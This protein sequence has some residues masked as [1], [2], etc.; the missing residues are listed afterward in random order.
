MAASARAKLE[1]CVVRLGQDTNWWVEE[2]SD[3]I[4]WDTDGLGILD[5]RQISHLMDLA[6]SL[7]DY[8]FDASAFD[9]AFYRFRI[10]KEMPKGRVR[11]VRLRASLSDPD[12]PLFALPDVVDEEKGPY[13]DFLE[14]ITR[15]RV[16]MLNDLVDFKQ[17]LTVEDMEEDIRDR[18]NTD[19]LEGRG[20]HVFQEVSA[21]LEYIPEG[22]ELEEEEDAKAD[23]G[24]DLDVELP[25][26]EEDEEAIEEDETMKWDED[27]DD[28]SE[29]EESEED[30]EEFEEDDESAEDVEEEK[31]RRGRTP[32]A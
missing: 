28:T 7:Q 11:L 4:T 29:D 6:E 20:V 24:D 13:A 18:Q 14:K 8:G 10:D 9:D 30:T 15:L 5:P 19:Y 27:E 3:P 17:P 22:Y 12:E 1:W 16:K 2:I 25:D 21:I 31:P 23:S 26:F 32:K